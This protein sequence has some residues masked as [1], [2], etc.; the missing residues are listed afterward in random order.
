VVHSCL[1]ALVVVAS[2]TLGEGGN[3]PPTARQQAA[4]DRA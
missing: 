2:S 3:R 1:L 4:V